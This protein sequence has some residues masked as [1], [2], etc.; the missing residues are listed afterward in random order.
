MMDFYCMSFSA[1]M[2]Y[3]H[4]ETFPSVFQ[5]TNLRGTL[6][7]GQPE[8]RHIQLDGEKLLGGDVVEAAVH[9]V[10]VHPLPGPVLPAPHQ[11]VF[12]LDER[13]P[14]AVLG[15]QA[16]YR[17]RGV[18]ALTVRDVGNFRSNSRKES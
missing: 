11:D 14:V 13:S 15:H 9:L 6:I 2:K 4:R 5:R 16:V 18:F 3:I 12:P 7:P 8:L 10:L 17:A 1:Y